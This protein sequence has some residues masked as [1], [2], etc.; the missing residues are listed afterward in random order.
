MRWCAGTRLR[1]TRDKDAA[2]DTRFRAASVRGRCVQA[3]APQRSARAPQRRHPRQQRT[4]IVAPFLSDPLSTSTPA[5]FFLPV[6]N[7]ALTC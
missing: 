6:P 1:K 4:A 2:R 7:T 3:L 5:T